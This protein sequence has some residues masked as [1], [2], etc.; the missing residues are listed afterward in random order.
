M[1]FDQTAAYVWEI[2]TL[3]TVMSLPD[4][5]RFS[6]TFPSNLWNSGG[7][8]HR[9]HP[10]PCYQIL[11]TKSSVVVILHVGIY[12]STLEW[13][14]LMP[15]V[16][17]NNNKLKYVGYVSTKH[18]PVCVCVFFIWWD[19]KTRM[20]YF[21]KYVK[22][23]VMCNYYHRLYSHWQSAWLQNNHNNVDSVDLNRA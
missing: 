17:T 4:C 23:Y 5:E 1:L 19:T 18:S 22:A 21:S 6:C 10:Y 9:T 20:A 14:A 7:K 3:F 13:F 8:P 12:A 16:I 2:E 11:I 15:Q